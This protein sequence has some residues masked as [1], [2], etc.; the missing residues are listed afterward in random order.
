MDTQSE[1][2]DFAYAAGRMIGAVIGLVFMVAVSSGLL[3]LCWNNFAPDVFNAPSMTYAQSAA[4]IGAVMTVSV[5][6]RIGGRR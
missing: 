1:Q 5:A 3:W 2:A 4:V 6:S